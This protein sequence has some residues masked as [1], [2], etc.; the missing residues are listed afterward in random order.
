MHNLYAQFEFERDCERLRRT[1]FSKVSK[2]LR[3]FYE[4]IKREDPDFV[5]HSRIGYL[6]NRIKELETLIQ[7]I[8]RN[9]EDSR[10]E[11]KS[12]A[13]LRQAFY[14]MSP[15]KK[16]ERELKSLKD[17][18]RAM[19]Y[20]ADL[21]EKR[22]TD[23]DIVRAKE[24]AIENLLEVN[25]SKFAKCVWHDDG[26]TPNMYVKNN[27]AY[28]F[29]CHKSGDVIDVYRVLHKCSFVEAVKALLR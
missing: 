15:I 12:P 25:K 18:L 5:S 1:H 19:V 14:I 9:Y 29:S 26:K 6:T 28:C 27:Y 21:K 7:E 11:N 4:E 17:S 22:I 8:N 13:W 16:Y 20:R 23:E 24:Y 2:D 3:E 10:R